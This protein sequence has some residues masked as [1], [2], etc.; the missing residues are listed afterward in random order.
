[1]QTEFLYSDCQSQ[2]KKIQP[3]IIKVR[4]MDKALPLIKINDI[5]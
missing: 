5:I 3:N 4:F 1:M 2:A